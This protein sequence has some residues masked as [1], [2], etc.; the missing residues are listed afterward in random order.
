MPIV[1]GM[2]TRTRKKAPPPATPLKQPTKVHRAIISAPNGFWLA[3]RMDRA[4]VSDKQLAG[5]LGIERQT[6]WKWSVG[7]LKAP[8]ITTRHQIAAFLKITEPELW[9]KPGF[10]DLNAAAAHITDEKDRLALAKMLQAH[11]PSGD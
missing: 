11:P 6:V 3:A 2:V 1:T 9:T 10:I 4:G 7:E 5:H 8:P